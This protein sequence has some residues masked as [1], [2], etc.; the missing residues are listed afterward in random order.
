MNSWISTFWINLR[1]ILLFSRKSCSIEGCFRIS[2]FTL[3]VTTSF[4]RIALMLWGCWPAITQHISQMF[5]IV[6]VMLVGII[7]VLV[8]DET[9][10][11]IPFLNMLWEIRI[12]H[13][14]FRIYKTRCNSHVFGVKYRFMFFFLSQTSCIYHISDF[15]L[16]LVPFRMV[17]VLSIIDLDEPS[18]Y[19]L[20]LR[21]L[22]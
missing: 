6:E 12:F 15:L 18:N 16:R 9:F 21:L 4:W 2:Q 10:V 7:Q 1:Q 11:L 17:L 20:I 8:F 5:R 13:C 22:I 14:W 19:I 3:L